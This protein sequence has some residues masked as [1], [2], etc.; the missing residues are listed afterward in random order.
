MCKGGLEVGW[1]GGDELQSLLFTV[2][3]KQMRRGDAA[4][5]HAASDF[6]PLYNMQGIV[7]HPYNSSTGEGSITHKTATFDGI[8][9][10][11]AV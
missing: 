8:L 5:M 1:V 10:L 2:S 3:P 7:T 6:V 11:T 4:H 9:D